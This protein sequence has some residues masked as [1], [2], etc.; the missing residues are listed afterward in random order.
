MKAHERSLDAHGF[1]R[2]VLLAAPNHLTLWKREGAATTR[3]RVNEQP[4][5][6]SKPTVST[7]AAKVSVVIPTHNEGAWLERTVQSVLDANSSVPFEIVV[8]DDNCTDGSIESVAECP[9]VVVESSDPG[10]VGCVTARNGGANRA[11]GD[12]LCFIDSHVLVP[13]H[14]LDHLMETS[15][16]HDDQCL[17]TGNVYNVTELDKPNVRERQFGYTLGKSGS[18]PTWHFY[19]RNTYEQPYRTP[20]CPGG[21]TFVAK[22]HFDS[23]GGFC[24][25][26][27]KWGGPDVEISLRNYMFGY[28]TFADPRVGIFHYYKNTSTKKRT[29]SVDFKDAFFNRLLIL[30]T[31]AEETEFQ[32][33]LEHYREQTSKADQIAAELDDPELFDLIESKRSRF[34][35]KW[36]DFCS[37]F[38]AELK[39][40]F[41]TNAPQ[42]SPHGSAVEKS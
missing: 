14:W 32:Q 6:K 29:F 24:E 18:K 1:G 37:D 17:V 15:Q 13:D 8:F 28:E 21:L 7:P 20:L 11:T 5:V 25:K 12:Y 40:C 2:N 31:Y 23:I 41:Q 36:T 34:R 9:N 33:L 27:R 22:A 35:R 3:V 4:Q 39:G 42:P 19:G 30:R 16:Q 26:I 10:G 38:E